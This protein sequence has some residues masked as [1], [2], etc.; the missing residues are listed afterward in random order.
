MTYRSP[1]KG[2]GAAASPDYGPAIQ[3]V[4]EDQAPPS[5]Y[6]IA[7]VLA[8]HRGAILRTV[9]LT[10]LRSVFIAPGLWIAGKMFKVELTGWKLIGTSLFAS[11]TISASMMAYYYLMSKITTP[12]AERT[13]LPTIQV[14]VAM[15]DVN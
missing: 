5:T 12:E 1:L 13:R 3:G 8:G 2:V 10:A 4:I 7:S 6:A 14:P 9:G 11:T 15:R